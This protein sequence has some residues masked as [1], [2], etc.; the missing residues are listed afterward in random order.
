MDGSLAGVNSHRSVEVNSCPPSHLVGFLPTTVS[1][2]SGGGQFTLM[3]GSRVMYWKP[4][5]ERSMTFCLFVFVLGCLC[6]CEPSC[7]CD[8]GNTEDTAS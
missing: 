1:K 2:T 5:S 3:E 4:T 7:G 6:V 8:L